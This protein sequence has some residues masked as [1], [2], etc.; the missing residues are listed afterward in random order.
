MALTTNTDVPFSSDSF[1]TLYFPNADVG[2]ATKTLLRYSEITDKSIASGATT[3]SGFTSNGTAYLLL[4]SGSGNTI[5]GASALNNGNLVNNN[6]SFV[7]PHIGSGGGFIVPTGVASGGVISSGGGA[8]IAGTSGAPGGTYY[9]PTVLSGGVVAVGQFTA[10]GHAFDAGGVMSGG[11]FAVGAVN[12]VRGSKSLAVGGTFQGDQIV[13]GGGTAENGLFSSGGVQ[14]VGGYFISSVDSGGTRVG[15]TNKKRSYFPD[16][17]YYGGAASAIGG[18]Y[19]AGGT[20][21]ILSAGTSISAAVTSGGSLMAESGGLVESAVV[22]GGG[23]LTIESGGVGSSNVIAGGT[24]IV[25]NGGIDSGTL[26]T[27]TTLEQGVLK[28]EAGGTTVGVTVNGGRE[29]VSGGSASSTVVLSGGTITVGGGA[30]RIV[31]DSA[32]GA[33]SDSPSD[34]YLAS[35]MKTVTYQS[36]DGS[37]QDSIIRNGGVEILSGGVVSGTNQVYVTKIYTDPKT[38]VITTVSALV[39][40]QPFSTTEQYKGVASNTQIQAGGRSEAVAGGTTINPVVYSGGEQIISSGGVASSLTASSGGVVNVYESGRAES[41]NLAGGTATIN[42]GGTANNNQIS[43]GGTL[44]ASSGGI[45]TGTT[46]VS[47]GGTL[48]LN[49][50]NGSSIINIAGESSS[51]PATVIIQDSIA[52]VNETFVGWSEGDRIVFQNVTSPAANV[53]FQGDNIIQFT[54][55]SRTYTLNINGIKSGYKFVQDGNNLVLEVCF[56]AGTMIR[57]KDGLVAVEDVHVGDT[58]MVRNEDGTFRPDTVKWVGKKKAQI[59]AV[60]AHPDVAGYPVR[61]QKG[62]LAEGV[63]FKD[64]LVTPEHCLF[65]NGAFVPVRML[66]NGNSISYDMNTSSYEYFHIEVDQH[67]VIEADGVLTESYLNTG[68]KVSFETTSEDTVAFGYF[69]SMKEWN[70][71]SAAPLMTTRE[72][73]EPIYHAIAERAGCVEL[74]GSRK[75]TQNADMHL[76]IPADGSVIRPVKKSGNVEFFLLPAGVSKVLIAS[77]SSRPSD[78]IGPFVDDRRELGVK[79]GKIRVIE[80]QDDYEITSHLNEEKL[81][82]WSVVENNEGRWTTGQAELTLRNSK[83]VGFKMLAVEVVS[84]ASYLEQDE[85]INHQVAV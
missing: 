9:N 46:T 58:I 63:P 65:I 42:G 47:G 62:A 49:G 85:V 4:V 20:G 83:N 7:D 31:V 18:V 34:A 11:S 64:L 78:F 24:E 3:V 79:V 17:A 53:T 32:T 84:T 48:V 72:F 40:E 69:E 56:L 43:S 38:G 41:L 71:D 21:V 15:I 61:I 66:V 29:E 76:V 81:S 27:S 12:L 6:C 10:K 33:T 73:V 59:R 77:K 54:T 1:Q 67:S 19:A 2:G 8:L 75:I 55:G 68:N 23:L 22:S 80:N 45:L 37:S 50:N 60:N 57:M 74:L 36:Q 30:R 82:G 52:N 44:N 14:T 13:L 5:S 28:V 26:V 25:R 51:N 35:G 70:V 39:S 16:S